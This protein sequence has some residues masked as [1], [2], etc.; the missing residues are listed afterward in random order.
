MQYDDIISDDYQGRL[1]ASD[2]DEYGEIQVYN[3]GQQRT[4]CFDNGL[5]QSRV[6]TFRPNALVH[7][8][9][10]AMFIAVSFG[11][12]NQVTILGLGGGC[13]ARAI[14][15][16]SDAT[17]VS[18]VE[19]R[20]SVSDI[21]QKHFGLPQDARFHLRIT[22]AMSHLQTAASGSSD[23]I[24]SDLYHA[25]HEEAVQ[26]QKEYLQQC[27]RVLK[28]NGW[29]VINHHQPPHKDFALVS[30]LSELFE[31]MY[32]CSTVDNNHVLFLGKGDLINGGQQRRESIEEIQNQLKSRL[33]SVYQRI[34]RIGDGVYLEHI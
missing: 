28:D 8:Y 22:D 32:V 9:L 26:T 19:L 29:L 25:N 13:L 2:R 14:R 17:D 33:D 34:T 24:F 7:E 11:P 21:A 4:L 5:I 31:H 30:R 10:R 27:R 1:L 16:I 20:K 15:A 6:D 3:Y 23:I 18:A 12:V